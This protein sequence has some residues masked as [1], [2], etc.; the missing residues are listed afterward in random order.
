MIGTGIPQ[1]NLIAVADV[2]ASTNRKYDFNEI[3]E[4]KSGLNKMIRK[5][6]DKQLP[7]Y[8]SAEA[9]R[10]FYSMKQDT[11]LYLEDPRFRKTTDKS[12]KDIYKLLR[13]KHLYPVTDVL[14]ISKEIG[15]TTV[16]AHL[17][18][19]VLGSV[20]ITKEEA[21][22]IPSK[23]ISNPIKTYADAGIELYGINT[24]Q[25]VPYETF[26]R[27]LYAFQQLRD[28]Q[29]L[30]VILKSRLDQFPNYLDV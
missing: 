27:T 16:M 23:D 11:T 5:L 7:R 19:E 21:K 28:S 12:T 29:T 25:P 8:A 20:W 30:D 17:L 24:Q 14:E 10:L 3:K 2:L 22:L 9:I 4:L 13:Y 18:H 1:K 6:D 26:N 15:N